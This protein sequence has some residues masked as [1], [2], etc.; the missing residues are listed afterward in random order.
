MP[1]KDTKTEVKTASKFA[2]KPSK[3]EFCDLLISH[4][5]EG[6]SFATFAGIAGVSR[7]TLYAWTERHP[8]F[9]E[10]KAIGTAKSHLWWEEKGKEGLW[11]M[12]EGPNLNV[13]VW[14][15]NMKNRFGWSDRVTNEIKTPSSDEMSKLK[16]KDIVKRTLELAQKIKEEEEEA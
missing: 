6:G 14:I 7:Q 8:D 10:A 12:R 4:M 15:A 13:G 5:T 2:P 3:E 1:K 11:L 16:S 9:N